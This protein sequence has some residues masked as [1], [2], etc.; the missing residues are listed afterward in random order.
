LKIDVKIF[1]RFINLEIFIGQDL[2][3]SRHHT[4][5]FPEMKEHTSGFKVCHRGMKKK[6]K[7]IISPMHSRNSSFPF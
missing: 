7:T 4:D 3:Q 5:R 6:L 2:P 1:K